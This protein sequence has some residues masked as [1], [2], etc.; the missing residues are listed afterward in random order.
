MNLNDLMIKV[1][2]I[3]IILYYIVLSLSKSPSYKVIKTWVTNENIN[4]DISSY[5]ALDNELFPSITSSKKAIRKGLIFINDIKANNDNNKLIKFGDIIKYQVPIHTNEKIKTNIGYDN[6]DIVYED[7][8]FAIV[9]KPQ[10]M[11]VFTTNSESNSNNDDDDDDDD[12]KKGE[13]EHRKKYKYSLSSNILHQLN[14]QSSPDC[15]TNML[16]RPIP[17]HRLD[18]DTGGLVVVAKTNV[19]LTRLSDMF[20]N[21]LIKKRYR[22]MVIGKLNETGSIS[23]N[24]DGKIAFTDYNNT[25]HT[26]TACENIVSIVDLF[27]HTGRKHQLRKH[28]KE[29]GCPILNDPKYCSKS[30]KGLSKKEMMLWALG[31]SFNHPITNELVNVSIPEPDLFSKVIQKLEMK[32][33]YVY[34]LESSDKSS[35]VGATKDLSRRL[36]QH[37]REV[38]GGAMLTGL[39]VYSGQTWTRLCYVSGFPNWREALRFEWSWKWHSKAKKILRDITKNKPKPDHDTTIEKA[40]VQNPE[41]NR[42]ITV[43]G[44]TYRKLVLEG[45][46]DG[47]L[48]EMTI[49]RLSP[50]QRRMLALK[51]LMTLDRSTKKS[52]PFSQWSNKVG[53]VITWESVEAKK[54]FE[55]VSKE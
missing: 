35:Y 45:K 21:R 53:P 42:W 14:M 4:L 55:I 16:R 23:T 39:K 26:Y 8:H 6:I 29:V 18:R 41:T 5:L 46:I 11:N 13:E 27:P 9:I 50:L 31:L 3:L 38:K 51:Q 33:S 34:L 52:M 36:R 49:Y 12:D 25:I 44:A 7:D 15:N 37:N 40:K 28:L 1:N 2:A 30:I 22:A 43:G 47:V 48:P 32:Q 24:I 54:I 19:A 10:G 17:V 20:S